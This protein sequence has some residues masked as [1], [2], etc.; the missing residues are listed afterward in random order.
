MNKLNKAITSF[1]HQK[2]L[3]NNE[4]LPKDDIWV[5]HVADL[6]TLYIGKETSLF[7]FVVKKR[8]SRDGFFYYEKPYKDDQFG[9]YAK[10]ILMAK[11]LIESC[12][13]YIKNNGLYKPSSD[14]NN[15]LGSIDNQTLWAMIT[16]IIPLLFGLGF[17][18]GTFQ[19]KIGKVDLL[20]DSTVSKPSKTTN[21][22]ANSKDYQAKTDSTNKK[23]N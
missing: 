12:Q 21:D 4:D 13:D 23:T 6:I 9:T 1:E 19:D 5:N 8:N 18:V 16:V 14:K 11:R 3:L 17:Y 22:K 2:E 7:E 10:D 15:F 20:P